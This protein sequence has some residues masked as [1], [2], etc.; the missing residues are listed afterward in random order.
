MNNKKAF[1]LIELL[2]VIAIIAL[3]LSVL[4]P[5]LQKA[6]SAAKRTVCQSN[7]KQLGMG[8][9]LYCQENDEKLIPYV[10]PSLGYYWMSPIAPYLDAELDKGTDKDMGVAFCPE[11]QKLPDCTTVQSYGASRMAW[12]MNY[13][14]WKGSYGN[15]G[16]WFS[17]LDTAA[18]QYF[19]RQGAQIYRKT[20]QFRPNTPLFAD[21]LWI[22]GWAND[23]AQPPEEPSTVSYSGFETF[24]VDRHTKSINVSHAEGS[25]QR[26]QIHELWTL[27]WHRQWK[28]THHDPVTW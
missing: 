28:A 25:V 17:D 5:S 8:L 9:I 3:L 1:T 20:F 4:L 10:D 18:S 14:E 16:W 12:Q 15:N 26:Y 11:A 7:L 2:V 6:K 24:W 13:G 19:G 27:P 23:D 21:A 22:T